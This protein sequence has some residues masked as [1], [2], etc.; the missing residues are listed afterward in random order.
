MASLKKEYTFMN[1]EYD[2][3]EECQIDNIYFFQFWSVEGF[4]FE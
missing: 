3:D 4:D 1:E 2:D